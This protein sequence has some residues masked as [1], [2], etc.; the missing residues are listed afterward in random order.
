MKKSKKTKNMKKH[1]LHV[2]MPSSKFNP[3]VKAAFFNIDKE[4]I[5]FYN[6]DNFL[7]ASYPSKY[8]V[9][10]EIKENI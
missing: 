2:S 8:T 4:R 1:H 5:N 10:E 3:V 9:I 7:I 6:V